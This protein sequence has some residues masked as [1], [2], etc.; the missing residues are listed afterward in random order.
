MDFN[1]LAIGSQLATLVITAAVTLLSGALIFKKFY[2][3]QINLALEKAGETITNL[4]KLGGVKSQEYTT[5]KNIEKLVA[6]DFIK[7]KIPELELVRLAVSPDTWD[8]IQ[9]AIETNP[10]AVIQLWNKYGHHFTDK[11]GS[12]ETEFDF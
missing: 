5:A 4:A 10:E 12:I 3:P 6:D 11:E 8:Q 1:W 7:Q 2:A 9:E